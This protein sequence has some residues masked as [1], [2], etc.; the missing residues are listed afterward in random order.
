MKEYQKPLYIAFGKSNKMG[1]VSETI[2]G[3]EFGV[4]LGI[5]GGI[6]IGGYFL[7]KWFESRNSRQ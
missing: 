5:F 4:V 6:L 2:R 7:W 3:I 1:V